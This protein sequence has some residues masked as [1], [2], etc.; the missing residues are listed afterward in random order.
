MSLLRIHCSLREAPQKCQWALVGNNREPVTGEGRV[1]QLPQR[2]ERVQL[3]IPAAETI[4]G[5]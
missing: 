5:D 4:G 2:A 3:V 1:E